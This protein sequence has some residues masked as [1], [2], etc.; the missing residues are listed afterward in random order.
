MN[1]NLSVKVCL[2]TASKHSTNFISLP[3]GSQSIVQLINTLM[4]THTQSQG[5]KWHSSVDST[6]MFMF[7]AS[8][9][10]SPRFR[11]NSNATVLATALLVT[12]S[13]AVSTSYLR[14]VQDSLKRAYLRRSRHHPI[15][16]SWSC[17]IENYEDLH[18]MIDSEELATNH[19]RNHGAIE[20]RDCACRHLPEITIGAATSKTTTI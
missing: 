6:V 3:K 5:G 1:D 10:E 2:K 8:K 12:S 9:C 7:R 14:L 13:F 15:S 18:H 20:G 11:V 4:T 19:W 16:C 17:Y